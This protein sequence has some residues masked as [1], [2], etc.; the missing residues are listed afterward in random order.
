MFFNTKPPLQDRK[1]LGCIGKEISGPGRP[2]FT[3]RGAFWCQEQV[4]RFWNAAPLQPVPSQTVSHL[5]SSHNRAVAPEVR[6]ASWPPNSAR[7]CPRFLNSKKEMQ[8]LGTCVL[9]PWFLLPYWL[10]ILASLAGW[11]GTVNR[12]LFHSGRFQNV[13][14]ICIKGAI[15]SPLACSSASH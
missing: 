10:Y 5:L 12:K 1:P 6:A 8:W 4:G 15:W 9:E 3:G 7:P 13:G 2:K 11:S 14:G